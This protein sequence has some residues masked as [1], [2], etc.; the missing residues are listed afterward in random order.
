MTVLIK[1]IET[2]QETSLA[3]SIRNIV[4]V[5]EFNVP[6]EIEIDEYEDSSFHFLALDDQNTPCGTA[7][8][9]FTD[10]G[11]KLER[12]AVLKEYRNSGL[13]GKLV[14]ALLKDIQEHSDSP[15]KEIYLHSRVE[16]MNL[17]L[18]H[19]FM[20]TGPEFSEGGIQHYKMILNKQ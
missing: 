10:K 3:R 20:K 4:F 14:E 9:R 19:G 2:E 13:G 18:R 8:W 7:R 12:I 15:G 16:A 6:A 17:Y 11:I 1:K 5:R